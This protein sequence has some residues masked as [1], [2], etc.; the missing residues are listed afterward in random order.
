MIK[1]ENCKP[2]WNFL[3]GVELRVA[4]A[5]GLANAHQLAEQAHGGES[6]YHF[7]EIMACPGGCLG[8]GGQPIPTDPEIREKRMQA[9]YAED[10]SQ[11]YT[12]IT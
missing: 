4:V 2:E 6:S 10:A 8:G 11:A 3:D 5:H 9:V 7:V 1:I 12:K